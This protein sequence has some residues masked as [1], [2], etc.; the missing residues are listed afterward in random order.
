M[1]ES[2]LP[3][4]S[5]PSAREWLRLVPLR[6]SFWP[7]YS[8]TTPIP[9]P[10]SSSER[11]LSTG[12]FADCP[13]PPAA[14]SRVDRQ[15]IDRAG[16]RPPVFRRREI[17]RAIPRKRREQVARIHH[18]DRPDFRLPARPLRRDNGSRGRVESSKRFCV[19]EFV[20]ESPFFC[21]SFEHSAISQ[22]SVFSPHENVSI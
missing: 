3:A 6:F 5:Q 14:C 10:R 17:S 20:L 13:R 15:R 4:L 8:I 19:L 16:G 7:A 18:L 11:S 9:W 1:A 21:L 2:T 22:K 12:A